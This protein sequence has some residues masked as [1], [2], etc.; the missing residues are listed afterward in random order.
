VAVAVHEHLGGRLDVAVAAADARAIGLESDLVLVR[1]TT[2]RLQSRR[3]GRAV[4]EVAQVQ[5]AAAVVAGRIR[6]PAGDR[7]VAPVAVPRA[8]RGEHD[9]VAPIRKQL[10]PWWL[11][12]CVVLHGTRTPD[13]RPPFMPR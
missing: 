12:T 2:N 13:R 6:M 7:T 4:V 10:Q 8:R 11:A 5:P 9:R 3:P 1:R